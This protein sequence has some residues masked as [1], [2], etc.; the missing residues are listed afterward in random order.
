MFGLGF[1][2]IALILIVALIFVGPKKIPALAKSLSKGLGEL[3]RASYDIRSTFEKPLE[4]IT[5][6]LQDIRDDLSIT[7]QHLAH[8]IE[9]DQVETLYEEAAQENPVEWDDRPA[10]EGVDAEKQST[11]HVR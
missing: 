3:R 6:P 7:A 9:T 4:D 8:Q 5:R 10:A 2:E 1:G 11:P